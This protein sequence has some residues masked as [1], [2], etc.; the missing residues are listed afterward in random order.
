[1][2]EYCKTVTCGC[3]EIPHLKHE[4]NFDIKD[5]LLLT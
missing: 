4:N 1:M 5:K 2:N 3:A